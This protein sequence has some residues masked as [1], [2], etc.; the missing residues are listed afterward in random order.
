MDA[1]IEVGCNG[2]VYGRGHMNGLYG[3]SGWTGPWR[4]VVKGQCMG[5]D[6]EVG[7]K[8]SVGGQGNGDVL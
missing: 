1:D 6:I 4:C 2:S 7:C 5:R 3:V 8:G